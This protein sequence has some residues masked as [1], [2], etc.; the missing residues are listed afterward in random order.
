M[1]YY[2]GK[3]NGGHLEHVLLQNASYD[4]ETPN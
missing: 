1:I 4:L 2:L 3:R